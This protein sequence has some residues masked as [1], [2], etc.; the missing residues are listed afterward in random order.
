M[1]ALESPS[2]DVGSSWKETGNRRDTK[3]ALFLVSKGVVAM[4]M[5]MIRW[6]EPLSPSPSVYPASPPSLQPA[7]AVNAITVLA[8][9]ALLRGSIYPDATREEDHHHLPETLRG[10]P[11]Y[12][13]T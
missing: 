9:I 6:C 8:E 10:S 12:R 13:S 5:M 1:M 3:H 7:S 2:I 11:N 4:M